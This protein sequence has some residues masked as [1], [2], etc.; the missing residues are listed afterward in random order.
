MLFVGRNINEHYLFDFQLR[1][2]FNSF[3]IAGPNTITLSVAK[4][5]AGSLS[6]TAGM[7]A[8]LATNCLVIMLHN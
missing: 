6:T 4:L 3:V 5:L 8:S 2:D 1:I 7:A